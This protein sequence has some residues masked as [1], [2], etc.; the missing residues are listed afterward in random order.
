MRDAPA[1][2]KIAQTNRK[3]TGIN[4]RSTGE[5]TGTPI[6]H[7]GGDNQEWGDSYK[8]SCR[9]QSRA[10][11]RMRSIHLKIVSTKGLFREYGEIVRY[12]KPFFLK[13][14]YCNPSSFNYILL[15]ILI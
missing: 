12:I 9:A 11:S 5:L 13:R 14:N 8:M 3:S 7:D 4:A 15:N 2:W 1:H 10:S 6:R